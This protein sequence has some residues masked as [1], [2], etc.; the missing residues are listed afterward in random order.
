MNFSPRRMRL[1][2]LIF[3]AP[4]TGSRRQNSRKAARESALSLLLMKADLERSEMARIS[5]LRS[6]MV[7]RLECSSSTRWVWALTLAM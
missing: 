6:L 1:T 7:P 2:T 3:W 4:L 5:P